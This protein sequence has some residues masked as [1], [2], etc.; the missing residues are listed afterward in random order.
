MEPDGRFERPVQTCAAR[1]YA[2]RLRALRPAGSAHGSVGGQAGE[3]RSHYGAGPGPARCRTT[4]GAFGVPLERRG[5]TVPRPRDRRPRAQGCR[6]SRPRSG[7][8]RNPDAPARKVAG[9][10]ARDDLERRIAAR[11]SHRDLS[12]VAIDRRIVDRPYQIGCIEALSAE[13]SRG[14]RT[15]LVEM[16]TDTGEVLTALEAVDGRLDAAEIVTAIPVKESVG[17]LAIEPWRSG[18]GNARGTPIWCRT[19]LRPSSI[20]RRLP[21]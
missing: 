13:V 17:D 1:R 5:S 20:S 7:R 3:H 4:R 15:L 21:S 14:R 12:A 9:F 10:Y 18:A 11:R 19:S 16:A 2:G 6:G 8:G